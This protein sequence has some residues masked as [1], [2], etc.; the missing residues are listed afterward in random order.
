VAD[1]KAAGFDP[2]HLAVDYPGRVYEAC[3]DIAIKHFYA[4]LPLDQAERQLGMRFIEGLLQ[5]LVGKMF[6]VSV[7]LLG[8]ERYLKRFPEHMKIDAHNQ[9]QVT[10]VQL[11]PREFRME[12]RGNRRLRPNYMAGVLTS[13][14]KGAG[15]DSTIDVL[16]LPEPG[17]FDLLIRW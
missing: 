17:A 15:V 10:P 16:Q 14:L 13:G 5:T 3:F 2:D 9:P 8:P 7:P 1:L 12:F 4:D 11:G 6:A